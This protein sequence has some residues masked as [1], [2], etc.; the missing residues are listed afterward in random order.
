MEAQNNEQRLLEQEYK[1]NPNMPKFIVKFKRKLRLWLTKHIPYFKNKRDRQIR[2]WL[3][4]KNETQEY[5]KEAH[6]ILNEQ[7]NKT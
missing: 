7:N 1:I 3:K 4:N 6:K 2:L 5:L